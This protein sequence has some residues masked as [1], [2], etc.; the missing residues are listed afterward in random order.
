MAE[1]PK[2]SW[3][4]TC[5]RGDMFVLLDRPTCEWCGAQR[6]RIVARQEERQERA[7]QRAVLNGED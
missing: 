3:T 7:R 6:D 2:T 1:K 4:H 5:R